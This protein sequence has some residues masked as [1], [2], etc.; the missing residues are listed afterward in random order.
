M[1]DLL[2]PVYSPPASVPNYSVEPGDNEQRLAFTRRHGGRNRLT[3]T[4][5]QKNG[6]LTL[7]LKDQPC[8]VDYPTYGRN[9]KISGAVGLKSGTGILSAV[10]KVQRVLSSWQVQFHN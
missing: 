5:T 4:F 8:G 10:V 9:S 1:A 2:P 3:T 6:S 7:T